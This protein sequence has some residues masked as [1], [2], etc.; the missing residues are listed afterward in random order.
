MP[1]N[2]ALLPEFDNEMAKTRECL[3]RVPDTKWDW[4][5]HSKSGSMGWLANH[6]AQM[7]GWT[8][9]MLTT[10]SL[11]IAP[12]GKQMEFPSAKNR[13]ELLAMFDKGTASA[14]TALAKA[15]DEQFAQ[16]WTLLQ[17]GQEFFS[18]PRIAVFR[19]MIMN[20]IIHH[21]GQLGVYFRLNDIPVPALYGPSADEQQMAA[22]AG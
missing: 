11:D 8:G 19:G 12:G 1:M 21:R 4:K 16:K 10:E 17:N 9:D 6:I 18:M 13:Q 7:A 3:S 22:T 15:T 2:Q 14:R 5:P 20:H